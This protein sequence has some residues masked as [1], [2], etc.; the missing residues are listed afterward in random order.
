MLNLIFFGPPGAGKGT[1]ALKVAQYY[2][3]RH[4]STGNIFREEIRQNTK[5]GLKV[6]DILAN[7]D[8]VPDKLLIKILENT[9]HNSP[10][11]NGFVFDGIPRTLRQAEALDNMMRH[12]KSSVNRV[13]SL[14]VPEDELIRRLV[15]RSQEQGRTDDTLEVIQRRLDIYHQHT[16]P[17]VDFYRKQGIFVEIPGIGRI[18]DVFQTICRTIDASG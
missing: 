3:L 17:L 10:D 6:K 11:S 18:E 15:I 7:G 13:I 1:Q 2:G 9:C 14:E 12:K 4:V 8:L 5:L 16:K